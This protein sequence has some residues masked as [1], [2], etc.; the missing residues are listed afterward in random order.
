MIR[1]LHLERGVLHLKGGQASDGVLLEHLPPPLH[2]RPGPV[3]TEEPS[4]PP[5]AVDEGVL[6]RSLLLGRLVSRRRRLSLVSFGTASLEAD[7]RV[8]G[9]AGLLVA[10]DVVVVAIFSIV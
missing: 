2:V 7:V 3:Q 8:H 1:L 4:P 9:A 10:S 6:P 5:T